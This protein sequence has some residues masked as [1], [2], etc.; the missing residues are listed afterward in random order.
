MGKKEVKHYSSGEFAKLCNIN[1]KTLFYY[2]E[3]GILKPEIVL[4]NGYRYYSIR[5]LEVF[6]V[7]NIMRKLKMSLKEIKRFLDNRTPKNTRE[8]LREKQEMIRDEIRALEKMEK[9]LEIKTNIIDLGLTA[10][11][12][13]FLE[14][15]EE[16]YLLISN[17]V[18]E[19]EEVYD[20]DTCSEL[21]NEAMSTEVYSGYPIGVMIN[22]EK[23]QAKKYT[24]YDYFFTKVKNNRN[25]KNI[26]KKAKGLYVCA[27]HFGY[28]DTAYKSYERIIKFME[29]NNLKLAGY[30][31]EETLIDE[32]ATSNTDEFVIKISIRCK[33]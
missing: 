28:Y 20:V 29:E 9:M 31:Y 26:V 5:Q 11:D 6:D 7:I 2:D 8:I 33:K 13:V 24:E 1:K 3:I 19:T 10:T 14:E 21:I 25:Q 12:S 16:E 17:K 4:E 30:S 23:L 18:K 27:Y 32:V 22:K 15:Q